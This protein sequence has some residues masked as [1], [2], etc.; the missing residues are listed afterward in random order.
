[1]RLF[2]APQPID[3]SPNTTR[4]AT[5]AARGADPAG[6]RDDHHRSDDQREVVG[7]DHPHRR[8][9]RH[10][11]SVDHLWQREHDDRGVGERQGYGKPNPQVL[12]ELRPFRRHS[13]A[14]RG[15]PAQRT[16]PSAQR[17]ARAARRSRR[18]SA[19]GVADGLERGLEREHERDRVEHRLQRRPTRRSPGRAR[20]T[21]SAATIRNAIS[22]AALTSRARPP[23]ATPSAPNASPPNAS[24]SDPQREPRP[25]EVD[26][27]RDEGRH[28]ATSPRPRSRPTSTIFSDSS[29]SGRD[30]PADEPRVGVLGALERQHPGREQQRDEHQRDDHRDRGRVRVG[31]RRLARRAR[32]GR[33]SAACRSSRA[34]GSRTRAP[35]SRGRRTR[36]PACSAARS[37]ELGGSEA[38]VALDDRAGVAQ[39]EQLDVLAEDLDRAA[40]EDLLQVGDRD[41]Q[42]LLGDGLLDVAEPRV[43]RLVDEL[44]LDRVLR[45]ED[46]LDRRAADAVA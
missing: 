9:D 29:P 6:H 13:G 30:E 16:R 46:Q 15:G 18:S 31:G 12:P 1:M 26:E 38:I 2:D 34:P 40:V 20:R 8:R 21:R 4:P 33:P 25:V 37:G 17:G 28:H 14:R 22:E 27:Q 39:A 42:D 44:P 36:R 23:I 35:R 43:D 5:S 45:V 24:A 7:D 19:E 3:A 41:A 32:S 10:V 11:Q